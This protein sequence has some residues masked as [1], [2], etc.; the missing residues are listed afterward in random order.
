M[1]KAKQNEDQ[2]RK[3]DLRLWWE[4]L[5]RSDNYKKVCEI[6]KKSKKH[7]LAREINSPAEAL[8]FFY[9]HG[10]DLHKKFTKSNK[11]NLFISLLETYGFFG[12]V[13]TGSFDKWWNSKKKQIE[14]VENALSVI[15]YLDVIKKDLLDCANVLI[16]NKELKLIRDLN[17]DNHQK[18]IKYFKTITDKDK[19]PTVQGLIDYFPRYL[20]KQYF[21]GSFLLVNVAMKS[22]KELKSQFNKFI[23]KQKLKPDIKKLELDS[24]RNYE[25]SSNTMIRNSG[26]RVDELNRY[27]EIFDLR[28]ELSMTQIIEMKE[29]NSKDSNTRSVFHQDLKKAKKII[30]NVE[31]GC[32][33]GNYQ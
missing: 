9:N 24:K 11:A 7:K 15:D 26:L 12:N 23:E 13:H 4:Y 8:I 1:V 33:P 3:E 14:N 29:E 20:K 18:I 32:F 2:K 25:I 17:T 21:G 31:L 19:E 10:L 30:K 22:K 5:K 27:L 6:I 16:S 28:K